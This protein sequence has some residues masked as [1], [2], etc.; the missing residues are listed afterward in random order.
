MDIPP[1]TQLFIAALQWRCIKF[2]C[3]LVVSSILVVALYFLIEFLEDKYGTG[4]TNVT[5]P[6]TDF[7]IDLDIP[8]TVLKSDHQLTD[9]DANNTNLSV[10][11]KFNITSPMVKLDVINNL[12]PDLEVEIIPL[13]NDT[14]AIVKIIETNFD[15]NGVNL[16]AK[17]NDF[18]FVNNSVRGI[19]VQFSNSASDLVNKDTL[20]RNAFNDNSITPSAE[21]DS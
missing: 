20:P 16:N 17:K 10:N 15:R 19:N 9:L 3:S 6:L 2:I 21:L 4:G 1:E 13:I 18:Y 5:S 11:L 14:N 7:H 12:V 8:I